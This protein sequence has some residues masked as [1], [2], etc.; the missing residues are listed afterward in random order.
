MQSGSGSPFHPGTQVG[1]NLEVELISDHA[2][3]GGSVNLGAYT[4]L[5]D[6]LSF[7]DEILSVTGGV[8]LTRTGYETTDAVPQLDVHLNELTLVIDRSDYT[9]P[10]DTRQAI[11]KVAH[12]M[13]AV[14]AAHIIT[15]TFFIY[16]SAE[17]ISYLRA[18]EP[19]WIPLANVRV[20]SLV[21]RRI[22]Y[23]AKFAVLYRKAVLATSVL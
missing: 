22:K 15:G 18:H 5:S 7:H 3:I 1:E 10:P 16:L 20:R 23:G 6:L 14:T 8:I 9:P 21:D 2:R 17:P 4:R 11:E 19:P 12:R 13:L